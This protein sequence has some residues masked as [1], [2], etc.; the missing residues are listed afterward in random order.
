MFLVPSTRCLQ[1][2]APL[3]FLW[4]ETEFNVSQ[5]LSL[6]WIR[7][8]GTLSRVSVNL[9][10]IL[11]QREHVFSQPTSFIGQDESQKWIAGNIV[12]NSS[13]IRTGTVSTKIS[14]T[15]PVRDK[16]AESALGRIKSRLVFFL[17]PRKISQS[18]IKVGLSVWILASPALFLWR[19]C[20]RVYTLSFRN[21][22]LHCF[23]RPCTTFDAFSMQSRAAR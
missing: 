4:M 17:L 10:H 21:K 16:V 18:L 6:T 1:G 15:D 12:A 7:F 5:I 8:L 14:Q 11:G 23:T 2:C 19:C 9:C 13:Y 20:Q 3:C 22:V